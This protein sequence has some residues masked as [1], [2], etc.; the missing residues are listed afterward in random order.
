MAVKLHGVK[1]LRATQTNDHLDRYLERLD[2]ALTGIP[3]QTRLEILLHQRD[4]IVDFSRKQGS[5][6]LD[7]VLQSFGEPEA[8]AERLILERGLLRKPPKRMNPAKWFAVTVLGFVAII[9]LCFTILIVKFTPLFEIDSAAGRIRILGGAIDI[10]DGEVAQR[11]Q[12]EWSNLDQLTTRSGSISVDQAT[13]QTIQIDF[14]NGQ[15]DVRRSSDQQLTWT[16]RIIGD[17]IE[18]PWVKTDQNLKLDLR[19]KPLVQCDFLVPEGVALAIQGANGAVEMTRPRFHAQV[20][21]ANGS[22]IFRPDTEAGYQFAVDVRQG[23]KSE[24]PATSASSAWK[25]DIA[26]MNGEV[27]YEP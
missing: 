2:A 23:T 12:H 17:L 10:K 26:V 9:L 13:P 25:I 24:F 4:Q 3:V 21:L 27:R 16:C 20:N 19:D 15:L 22:V 14:A 5:G 1:D 7:S 18:N 8:L 6:N 11:L